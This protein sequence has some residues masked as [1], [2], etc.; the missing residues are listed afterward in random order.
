MM[1]LLFLTILFPLV[2][3]T[4]LAFSAG[5]WSEKRSALIGVG[6]IGLS[7]LVM[8]G[9][10]LTYLSGSAQQYV[11]PLWTWMSVGQFKAG[12]TLYLDGLSL[13]MLGVVTG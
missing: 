8:F 10:V 13:T 6:S 7:A 11:Q 2:G 1:S 12:L 3:A 9:L 4:L 5:H